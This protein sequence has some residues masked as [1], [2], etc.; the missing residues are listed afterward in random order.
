MERRNDPSCARL[1]WLFVPM[2]ES[3]ESVTF[4]HL[5]DFKVYHW[6]VYLGTLIRGL[7]ISFTQYLFAVFY[8]SWPRFACHSWKFEHWTQLWV[9]NKPILWLRDPRNGLF[10]TSTNMHKNPNPDWF[11]SL[12]ELKFIRS[13]HKGVISYRSPATWDMMRGLY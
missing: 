7:D 12:E 9:I 13:R 11:L 2:S 3:A 1:T 5:G 6:W 8:R 4:G 10:W